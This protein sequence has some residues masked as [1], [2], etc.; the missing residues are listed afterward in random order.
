MA[1]R[2]SRAAPRQAPCI[3]QVYIEGRVVFEKPEPV[4]GPHVLLT[5]S[6]T[7]IGMSEETLEHIF[8]PFF[9]TKSVGKGTGLGLSMVYGIVRQ[10]KGWID[11]SSKVGHGTTVQIFLPRTEG[12]LDEAPVRAGVCHPFF[13]KVVE[14]SC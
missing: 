13:C 9:T 7:G 1:S 11:V 2:L 10:S 12:S 6:D 5:I 8:E 3:I 4:S 14:Q